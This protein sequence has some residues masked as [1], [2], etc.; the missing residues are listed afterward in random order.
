M[1]DLLP[2]MIRL[3]DEL[4]SPRLILRPLR[5]DDAGAIFAMVAAESGRLLGGTELHVHDWDRCP[6]EV[7]SSIR[8]SNQ[9]KGYVTDAGDRERG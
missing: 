5:P 2:T 9:R 7:G 4:R 8:A 1:P 3:P 6:L